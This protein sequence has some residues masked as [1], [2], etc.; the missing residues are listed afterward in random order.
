MLHSVIGY[1]L[2]FK[3]RAKEVNVLLQ[4][5]AQPIQDLQPFL[6]TLPVRKDISSFQYDLPLFF[7]GPSLW[8]TKKQFQ[9]VGAIHNED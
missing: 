2:L 1:S 4:S 8:R 9:A 3:L 5:L 7:K 6:N